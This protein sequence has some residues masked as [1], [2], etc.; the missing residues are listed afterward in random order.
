ME[1]ETWRAGNNV[2]ADYAGLWNGNWRLRMTLNTARPLPS[3]LCVAGKRFEIYHPG[4]ERTCWKCGGAHAKKD[5]TTP[6]G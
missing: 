5:C 2:K 4:Q 3:T 6:W 1:K